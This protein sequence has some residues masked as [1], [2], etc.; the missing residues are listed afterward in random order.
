MLQSKLIHLANGCCYA[1]SLIKAAHPE[2]GVCE[3][4]NDLMYFVE[5]GWVGEDGYVNDPIQILKNMAVP[6][7]TVAKV[8]FNDEGYVEDTNMLELIQRAQ[9]LIGCFR[10]GEKTHFVQLRLKRSVDDL[11]SRSYFAVLYDPL[12]YSHTVRNGKLDSLRVFA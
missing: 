12:L 2:Y 6:V 5:E 9:V 1:M 4:V 8:H 10:N 7:R 3:A 11:T